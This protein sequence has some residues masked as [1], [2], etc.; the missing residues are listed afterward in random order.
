MLCRLRLKVQA[1]FCGRFRDG[2]LFGDGFAREDVGA[3]DG[4]GVIAGSL[5]RRDRRSLLPVPVIWWT[6][7]RR[8]LRA[9]AISL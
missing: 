7:Q 5:R 9:L 1:G 3:L 2:F 6:G 8:R 4:D